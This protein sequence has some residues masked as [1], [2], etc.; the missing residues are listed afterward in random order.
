MAECAY[1]KT[2]TQL[3]VSNVPVCLKCADARTGKQK[4]ETSEREVLNVL[5][6]EYQAATE[7]GQAAIE[8]FD[9][10]TNEIPSR[11]PHPDGTPAN[12][13]RFARSVSGQS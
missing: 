10:V 6:R 13:Q 9:A 4:P 8:A 7:R 3:Y 11:I 5:Q 2:E 1:C 12:Q